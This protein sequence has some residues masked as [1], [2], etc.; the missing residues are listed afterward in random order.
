M[1]FWPVTAV[2]VGIVAAIIGS[3]T[4]TDRPWWSLPSGLEGARSVL[5]TVAA[6]TITVTATAFSLSALSVQLASTAYTPRLVEIYRSD[7]VLQGVTALV[8][9]TFAFSVTA[10]ALISREALESPGTAPAAATVALVLAVATIVAIVVFI[11]HVLRSIRIDDVVRR[12]TELTVE[13]LG[14]T[15][16]DVIG[17]PDEPAAYQM[18]VEPVVV[19]T[20]RRG[21]LRGIDPSGLVSCLPDGA[22][23]RVDIAIGERVATGDRVLT[24]WATDEIDASALEQRLDLADG[25]SIDGDAG[26]GTRQLTDVALRALSPGVNDPATAA[27]TVLHLTEPLRLLQRHEGQPRVILADRSVRILRPFENAGAAQVATTIAQIRRAAAG[28]PLVLTALVGL[29]GR[30]HDEPDGEVELSEPLREELDAILQLVEDSDASTT[31]RKQI[32]AQLRRY[33]LT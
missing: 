13:E 22:I 32:E 17:Q 23:C 15:G 1:F 3:E 26:F 25:R 24:V 9:G 14:R 29:I 28:H 6:G 20:E 27:D 7:R 10:L 5:G 4:I 16:S 21:W 33:R 12:I 19:R 18:D 11:D 8:S 2:A 30:L 31:E